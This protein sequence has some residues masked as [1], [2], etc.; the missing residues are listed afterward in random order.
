[1]KR[2]APLLLLLLTVPA[3]AQEQ[4]PNTPPIEATV[5]AV[6]E[7]EKHIP[8]NSKVYIAPMEGFENYLAAAFRKKN[9]PLTIVAEKEFADFEITGTSETKKAGWAKTIFGSGK[10]EETA[11]ISVINMRTK[12]IVYADSSHRSDAW[13][14]KRSTAEK[15]A[16]YLAKKIKEDA[17]RAT[18]SR[19]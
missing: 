6:P 14:G 2:I 9:V 18:V 3:L 1:M 4:K 10:S 7:D 8:A 11:S 12:V 15:L 16:K 13:R 5:A 19:K 17:K